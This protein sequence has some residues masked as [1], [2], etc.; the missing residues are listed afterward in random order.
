MR[1]PTISAASEERTIFGWVDV[2]ILLAIFGL[3][4]RFAV[5][6][7]ERWIALRCVFNRHRGGFPPSGRS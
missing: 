3:L 2:A 4:W 5:I 1:T 7:A 6:H